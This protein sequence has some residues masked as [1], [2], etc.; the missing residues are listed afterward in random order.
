[1]RFRK[2]V[3]HLID[4]ILSSPP[5]LGPTFINKVDLSDVYMRIWVCLED[6]PSVASLAP[7]ATREEDQLFRFHLS[8]PMGYV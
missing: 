5:E 2:Y 3:Y 1:M 8:V 7:K 4:C 6:I